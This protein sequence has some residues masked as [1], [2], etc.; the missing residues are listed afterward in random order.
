MEEVVAFMGLK[1]YQVLIRYRKGG[2]TFKIRRI[3]K[4]VCISHSWSHPCCYR[5]YVGEV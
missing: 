4:A 5:V 3:V 2:S 1:D